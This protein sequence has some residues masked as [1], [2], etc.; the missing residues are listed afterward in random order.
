[1]KMGLMRNLCNPYAK[2]IQLCIVMHSTIKFMKS[3]FD[4]H[5]VM[6][7][8]QFMILSQYS[9]FPVGGGG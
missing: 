1:M 6:R 5:V 4:L 3:V 9:N 2:C 7:K 8:C